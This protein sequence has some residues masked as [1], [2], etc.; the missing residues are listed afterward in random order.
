LA[1]P[2]DRVREAA[3]L[4]VVARLGLRGRGVVEEAA[5][6]LVHEL[7]HDRTMYPVMLKVLGRQFRPQ[8]VLDRLFDEEAVPDLIDGRA[9]LVRVAPQVPRAKL[10]ERACLKVV[11]GARGEQPGAQA[12]CGEVVGVAHH[13]LGVADAQARVGREELV[14]A[15]GA[16]GVGELVAELVW[17]I[18]G[19]G[20]LVG[21]DDE[22]A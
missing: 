8:L 10:F 20:L 12:L 19:H 15:D 18:V 6:P 14:E 7:Q 4:D 3:P 21:G 22:G 13:H 1:E 9:R 16:E 17:V 11:R 2:S 5:R